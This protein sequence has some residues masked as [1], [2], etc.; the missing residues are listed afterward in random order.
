MTICSRVPHGVSITAVSGGWPS[1]LYPARCLSQLTVHLGRSCRSILNAAAPSP[2]APNNLRPSMAPSM[3][4]IPPGIRRVPRISSCFTRYLTKYLA[5]AL[6]LLSPGCACALFLS[7]SNLWLKF[8]PA[9]R[10]HASRI[11]LYGT[12]GVH[13]Y[14]IAWR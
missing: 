10:F 5:A 4:V 2:H 14:K 11:S 3:W 1:W 9:A 7:A 8:P 6:A 12:A 13:R